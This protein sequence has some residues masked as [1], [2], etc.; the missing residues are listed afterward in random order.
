MEAVT[1]TGELPG[2]LITVGLGASTGGAGAWLDSLVKGGAAG[3]EVGRVSNS[4][5]G[6][7]A[8]P[9]TVAA[10]LEDAGTCAVLA[11]F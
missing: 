5:M 9:C 3:V 6:A 8:S 7:A 2:V 4:T 10:V 1:G 11:V